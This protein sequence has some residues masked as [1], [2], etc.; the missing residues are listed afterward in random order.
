M[1]LQRLRE[2]S[3][4]RKVK[5]KKQKHSKKH[6]KE[7]E[8]NKRESRNSKDSGDRKDPTQ[9]RPSTSSRGDGHNLAGAR[10]CKPSTV[11]APVSPPRPVTRMVV[12]PRDSR[13]STAFRAPSST[14]D[15]SA[16]TRDYRYHPQLETSTPRPC[17]HPPIHTTDAHQTVGPRQTITTHPYLDIHPT[18][19]VPLPHPQPMVITPPVRHLRSRVKTPARR[20]PW[21]HAAAY[22]SAR[23]QG[24]PPQAELPS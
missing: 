7:G 10:S 9:P 14:T 5:P 13:P 24:F 21:A 22:L 4:P 16:G 19:D 23:H 3:P 17:R 15:F 8:D 1:P 2:E 11:T 6:H 20:G 18:P 12:P